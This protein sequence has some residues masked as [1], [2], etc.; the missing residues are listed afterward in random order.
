M[1]NE[2]MIINTSGW[3]QS[4]AC[5]VWLQ[6]CRNHCAVYCDS[7][8]IHSGCLPIRLLLCDTMGKST[9]CDG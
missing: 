9:E 4:L 2:K 8:P 7:G 1:T 5:R 6:N 3:A